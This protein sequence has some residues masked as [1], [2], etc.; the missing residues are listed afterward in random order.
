MAGLVGEMLLSLG[1]LLKATGTHD[2]KLHFGNIIALTYSYSYTIYLSSTKWITRNILIGDMC[3]SCWFL[4]DSSVLF[5]RYDKINDMFAFP[6]TL[7]YKYSHIE[8]TN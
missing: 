8:L 6:Y 7:L 1:Y 2:S 4:R 3:G 5:T